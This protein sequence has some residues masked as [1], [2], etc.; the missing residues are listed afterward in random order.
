MKAVFFKSTIPIEI[1]EEN[2]DG[3]IEPKTIMRSMEQG[4][5]VNIVEYND[6]L[7]MFEGGAIWWV[8]DKTLFN[9]VNYGSQNV[10]KCCGG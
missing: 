6:G 8:P 9:I 4:E 5:V 7:M 3:R 1:Y 2:K 10:E